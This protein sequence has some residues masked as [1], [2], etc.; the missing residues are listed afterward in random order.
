MNFSRLFLSS[1]VEEPNAWNFSL[2]LDPLKDWKVRLKAL[3]N[4]AKAQEF[5]QEKLS[6]FFNQH[7]T[8]VF[9]LLYRGLIR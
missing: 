8:E 6:K 9:E 7:H 1:S 2:V 5:R 4:V 3:H